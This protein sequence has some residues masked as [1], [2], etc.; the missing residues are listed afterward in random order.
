MKKKNVL[1]ILT[2]GII[3]LVACMVIPLLQVILPTFSSQSYPMQSYIEFLSDKYYISILIRTIKISLITTLICV[4]L[5]VPTAYFISRTTKKWRGILLA[6]SIFPLMTNSVVRSFAWI[7]IL[8][9]T[10]IVNTFLM[11][12]GLIDQPIKLLYSEFAIILGSVYL[13]LPLMIV[14]VA[15]VMETI[16]DD[17]MEASQSL[18]ASRIKSFMKV[19]FPLSVSG[20]IV[21]CILVFTGTLTAYTTPQL[22]GGNTNLMLSTFI[23]QQA[24]ML[25]D[26][27]SASV[28]AFIMIII[29]L[30]VM[31][32]LQTVSKKMDK[33]G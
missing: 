4:G 16:E 11:N 22:L 31:K 32:V 19:V 8:G 1:M 23:Y 30:F 9:S 10:G 17:M 21:G 12:I 18:G 7:N 20:I 28:I 27:H 6:F 33:R 2:P 25:G 14:T 29:T 13:F 5:G 24:M 26:W 15:G 3:L